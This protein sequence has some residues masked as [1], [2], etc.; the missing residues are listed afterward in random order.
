MGGHFEVTAL[1]VAQEAPKT[2][3]KKIDST[4]VPDTRRFPRRTTPN[5]SGRGGG[6]T[7]FLREHINTPSG[8][9]Q[10]SLPLRVGSTYIYK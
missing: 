10:K 3:G 5:A 6:N 7:Y 2:G 1:N 4:L 9:T 8:N